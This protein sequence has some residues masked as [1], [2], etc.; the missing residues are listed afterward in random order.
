MVH[1]LDGET[2]EGEL[3]RTSELPVSTPGARP[4]PGRGPP[5][6]HIRPT[7]GRPYRRTAQ[8]GD[9]SRRCGQAGVSAEAACSMSAATAAGCDT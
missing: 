1:R 2:V 5:T 8:G 6:A 7:L 4:P 3:T 9:V